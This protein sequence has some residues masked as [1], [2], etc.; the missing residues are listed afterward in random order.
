MSENSK[1]ESILNE[2]NS[3]ESQA[4]VLRNKYKDIFSRNAELEK[5][6]ADLKKEKTNLLQRISRLEGEL[7]PFK[8]EGSLFNSLNSKEKENLKVRLQ[9]LIS[10]IDYHLSADRQF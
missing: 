6:V 1:Y 3:I 9:N 7:E 4:S 5:T 2:L 10:K 8:D